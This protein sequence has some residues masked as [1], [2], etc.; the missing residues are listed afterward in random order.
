[1]ASVQVF[2]LGGLSSDAHIELLAGEQLVL[3]LAFVPWQPVAVAGGAPPRVSLSLFQMARLFVGAL[4]ISPASPD[5][6]AAAANSIWRFR[7][8]AAAW[9]RI[10]TELRASSYAAQPLVSLRASDAALA[11]MI[12]TTPA[13]L[14]LVA[15]D[16]LPSEAFA[17]PL[18]GGAANV[19][20]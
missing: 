19:A 18:A 5:Q 6:T 20:A 7:L 15:A 12:P 1:M 2:P 3:N 9:I 10:L 8:T 17:G 16:W 13:N 4:S 11:S 14:Q